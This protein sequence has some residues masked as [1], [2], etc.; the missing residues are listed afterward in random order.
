MKSKITVNIDSDLLDM[1]KQDTDSDLDSIMQEALA[2]FLGVKHIWVK[3][4]TLEPV[5]NVAPISPLKTEVEEQKDVMAKKHIIKKKRQPKA[6]LKIWEKVK[7]ELDVEFTPEDYWNA[8]KKCGYG[9]KDS[10]KHSTI[11]EHLRLMEEVEK[12]VKIGDKPKKYRKL[13]IGGGQNL[14]NNQQLDNKQGEESSV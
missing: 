7:G 11:L 3:A 12:I 8:T 6:I 13:E 14:E 5:L 10:A 1:I 2:Q 9:Y 4:N